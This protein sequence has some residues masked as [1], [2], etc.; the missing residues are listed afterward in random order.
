MTSCG[1]ATVER[2]WWRRAAFREKSGGMGRSDLHDSGL[3][4]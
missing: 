4:T 2:R 3:R 1:E